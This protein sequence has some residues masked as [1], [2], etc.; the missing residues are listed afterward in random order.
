MNFVKNKFIGQ[1]KAHNKKAE[2]DLNT[3]DVMFDDDFKY[4]ISSNWLQIYELLENSIYENP[5][6]GVKE[7][8]FSTS[9]PFTAIDKKGKVLIKNGTKKY[10][11]G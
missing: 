11:N 4:Y 2:I 7:V 6:L 1:N 9:H 10:L 8:E 5:P 3:F